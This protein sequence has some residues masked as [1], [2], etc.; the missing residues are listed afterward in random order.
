MSKSIPRQ[1]DDLI[2]GL[3]GEKLVRQ[4]LED[5][6]AGRRTVAACLVR[7]ARPR[8][9]R[10]GLMPPGIPGQSSESELQLYALL[11]E[12]GGDAYSRYNALL[13]ELVSFESALDTRR[14]AGI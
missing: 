2:S 7:I 12:Q 3:P 8:L 9:S 10:V 6:S 4:G 1:T 11:S 14:P 5:F 13:R